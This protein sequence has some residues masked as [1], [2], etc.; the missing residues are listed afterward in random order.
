M[1][2][3]A[4][5]KGSAAK[6]LVQDAMSSEESSYEDAEGSQKV[7]GYKVKRLGWQSRNL[8]KIKKKLD[9][10]YN[11]PLT[12]RA[13]DRILPRTVAEDFSPQQPPA[14]HDSLPEWAVDQ[15]KVRVCELYLPSAILNPSL[16]SHL[17]QIL[18]SLIGSEIKTDVKLSNYMS[19]KIPV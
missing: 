11:K 5:E 3:D 14:G 19:P 2:H 7:V 15:Q 1:W 16:Q 17:E 6:V 18:E 9:K 13:R 4:R 10:A 8:R 12:K